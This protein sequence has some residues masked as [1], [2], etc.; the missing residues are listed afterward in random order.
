MHSGQERKMSLWAKLIGKLAASPSDRND[1]SLANRNP[2][3]YAI[4][5]GTV[6]NFETM[7]ALV[8][9]KISGEYGMSRPN[10]KTAPWLQCP[11]CKTRY[12]LVKNALLMSPQQAMS[13]ISRQGTV[14]LG[15]G[16]DGD[17]LASDNSKI[18]H[19]ERHKTIETTIMSII[20]ITVKLAKSERVKW[21]CRK[22][23]K[24]ANEFPS[25][26]AAQWSGS[27]PSAAEKTFIVEELTTFSKV[28]G[29]W[30]S[31]LGLF[32]KELAKAPGHQNAAQPAAREAV[33]DAVKRSN[34]VAIEALLPGGACD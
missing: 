4:R 1:A 24:E 29:P 26:W 3:A 21:W 20:E 13:E 2:V 27:F 23:G 19:L 22:C 16:T 8:G 6:A 28:K 14:V 15:I 34:D 17:Y 9:K 7:H 18:P 12:D 33:R 32:L 25:D 10:E 11:E 5:A 31:V 30:Q